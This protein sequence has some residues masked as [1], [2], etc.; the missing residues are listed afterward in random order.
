MLLMPKLGSFFSYKDP[1]TYLPLVANISRCFT[2]SQT[3]ELA[4]DSGFCFVGC[5]FPEM[6]HSLLHAVYTHLLVLSFTNI[7]V[8][9]NNKDIVIV[10]VEQELLK[11]NMNGIMGVISIFP[12]LQ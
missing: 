12:G 4:V 7:S 6:Q 8:Y 11:Q 2:P 1:S 5:F 9:M 10:T 3:V